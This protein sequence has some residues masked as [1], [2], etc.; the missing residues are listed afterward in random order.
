MPFH[1]AVASHTIEFPM[2][3]NNAQY[4]SLPVAELRRRSAINT[5]VAGAAMRGDPRPTSDTHRASARRRPDR[6]LPA[7]RGGRGRS[8]RCR[9][10]TVPGV[11]GH[12]PGGR[13]HDHLPARLRHPLGR[14][15]AQ[16]HGGGA[17]GGPP[18]RQRRPRGARARGPSGSA[19]RTYPAG[20]Y[21]VDMHQPKRGIANV[22]ARRRAGTSAPSVSTMYDISGW[23]LGPAVGRERGRGRVAAACAVAR[24]ARAGR[25]ADRLRGPARRSAAA[26]RRPAGARRAQ[27]AARAGSRGAAGGRRHGDRAGVGAARGPRL[28]AGPVRT[29]SSARPRETGHGRAAAAP[30]WPRRSRRVSCS[31]C[32][33]WASTSRRCRRPCSTRAST[34]PAADVLFVSAGLDRR[35]P[36]AG[37][38]HGPRRVPGRARRGVVGPGR[39]APAFNA[40]AGLLEGHAGGGQRGRQRRRAGG[41]LGRRG[42]GRRPAR[43]PSSTPRCG[44][45]TSAAGSRAEQS[46]G[47]GE[48]AGRR[49][50]G[51]PARTARAARRTRRAGPRSS[52]VRR[53]T[54]PRW[55]CSAPSRCSVTIPK[56]VFAQVGRALLMR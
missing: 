47:A 48:P 55:C 14:A 54:A 24:A 38:P 50:T 34:G 45:P 3:V 35:R 41:E 39:R 31:R 4:D 18:G 37:G 42:H 22:H 28:L 51:G 46:Y 2:A 13:L 7:R 30:G 52:A 17:A 15:S 40:A 32:G 19:G 49:A 44:S 12:R 21:V 53:R 56:G 9:T 25:R 29:S 36:D 1:G 27:L 23:S 8:G 33:R 5:D 43:T 6:G 16:R 10:E 11:P 20:S 26:A